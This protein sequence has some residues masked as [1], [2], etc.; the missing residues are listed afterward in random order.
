MRR[1]DGCD[2]ALANVLGNGPNGPLPVDNRNGGQCLSY[3]NSTGLFMSYSCFRHELGFYTRSPIP[4]FPMVF[5]GV[6]EYELHMKPRA[7]PPWLPAGLPGLVAV[8]PKQEVL[9]P[10]QKDLES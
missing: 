3:R 6:A 8:P 7:A 9:E 10:N 2:D 4:C 5:S 1:V